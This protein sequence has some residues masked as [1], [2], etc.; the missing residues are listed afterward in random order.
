MIFL[1]TTK[2]GREE[3][4]W[5]RGCEKITSDGDVYYLPRLLE[6]D[7]TYYWRLDAE[8]E[9]ETTYKGNVWSLQSGDERSKTGRNERKKVFHGDADALNVY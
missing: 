5:E 7:T 3:R 4:P 8:I 2:G 9:G 1:P 6:P